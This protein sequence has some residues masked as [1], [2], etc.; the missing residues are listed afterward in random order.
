MID[1]LIIHELYTFLLFIEY[2][3]ED[4]IYVL[5]NGDSG[6]TAIAIKTFIKNAWQQAQGNPC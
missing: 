4:Y 5:M 2:I 1:S 6:V 3:Q